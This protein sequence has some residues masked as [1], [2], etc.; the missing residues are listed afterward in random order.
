MSSLRDLG[1]NYLFWVSLVQKTCK[2]KN[3][4]PYF[5]FSQTR[6]HF[7]QNFNMNPKRHSEVKI[8]FHIGI[9]A[10]KTRFGLI[11]L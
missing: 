1:N 8:S 10:L 7:N 2:R 5:H 11:G 9:W 3:P 6:P 4:E